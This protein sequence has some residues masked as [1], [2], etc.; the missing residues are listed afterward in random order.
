MAC[1]SVPENC[2]VTGTFHH[3]FVLSVIVNHYLAKHSRAGV[4]GIKLLHDNAPAHSSAVVKSYLE[5]FH[6]QVLPHLSYSP[7]LVI[8]GLTHISI[9]AFEDII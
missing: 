2:S 9:L 1:V 8:S 3:D 7:D 5:E 6:I 4:R